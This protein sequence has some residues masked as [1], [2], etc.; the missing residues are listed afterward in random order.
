MGFKAEREAGDQLLR[1]ENLSKSIDGVKILDRVSFTLKKGD[2]AV[3][4]GDTELAVTTLFQILMGELAADCGSFPLGRHDFALLFP[5]R[6]RQVF[7][8]RAT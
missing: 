7:R 8:R 6:Q 1:V 4:I 3:F 2:K 5:E